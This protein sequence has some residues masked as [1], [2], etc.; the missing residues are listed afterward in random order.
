MRT[1]LF[2]HGHGKA[3]RTWQVKK[4]EHDIVIAF[5]EAAKYY[6]IGQ[7]ENRAATIRMRYEG[8]SLNDYHFFVGDGNVFHTEKVIGSE[9]AHGIKALRQLIASSDA[10]EHILAIE[11]LNKFG[12]LG[13]DQLRIT[14][15]IFKRLL[16]SIGTTTP[17]RHANAID[18][19]K[20]AIA[21]SELEYGLDSVY[22]EIGRRFMFDFA[23][24]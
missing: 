20:L 10:P 21:Q 16:D 22:D 7:F 6:S 18:M 8:S 9:G 14:T 5:T 12:K 2:A 23:A 1:L 24:E 11:A 17:S 4:A 13:E 19:M 3:L 15:L